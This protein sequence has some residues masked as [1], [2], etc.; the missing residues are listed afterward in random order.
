V[1]TYLAIKF[2]NKSESINIGAGF[3]ISIKEL[4]ELIV[5]LT[6]LKGILFGTNQNQMASRD[7]C[8]IL[9]KR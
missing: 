3:E 1:A 9:L 7:G 6:V 5:Q 4:A 2:Y 8:S